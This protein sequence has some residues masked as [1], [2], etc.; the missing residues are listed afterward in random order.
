MLRRADRHVGLLGEVNPEYCVVLIE[1][2][3]SSKRR[4][5]TGQ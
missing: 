2:H 3:L 1:T 4:V 5:L